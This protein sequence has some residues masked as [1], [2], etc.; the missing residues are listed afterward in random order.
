M[1]FVLSLLFLFLC[2]CV[3]ELVGQRICIH[4]AVQFQMRV[5]DDIISVVVVDIIFCCCFCFLG[6]FPLSL[7]E[8]KRRLLMMEIKN[9]N[10]SIGSDN[11][12]QLFF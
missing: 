7:C 5:A 8:G 11:F 10:K 12:D 3:F 4:R 1:C 2:V 9:N 6:G